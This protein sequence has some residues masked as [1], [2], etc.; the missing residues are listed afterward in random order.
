MTPIFYPAQKVQEAGFGWVL[1]SNP[2]YWLIDSY[3]SVLLYGHWP[4]IKVLAAFS[5]VALV[6]LAAGSTF[7]MAQKPRFPDLL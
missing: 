7:F 6:L 5:L 4:Q 3:R 1:K 2:M